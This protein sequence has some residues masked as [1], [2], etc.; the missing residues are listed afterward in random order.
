MSAYRV[1]F[2]VEIP[3]S[4]PLDEVEQFISFELGERA[5]LRVTHSALK[6]KD[7]NSFE[8]RQVLVDER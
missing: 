5:S 2:E 7:L 4:P 3:G 8:V 1:T 6:N